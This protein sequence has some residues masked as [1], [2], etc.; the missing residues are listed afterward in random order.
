M[1]P[2]LSCLVLMTRTMFGWNQTHHFSRNISFSSTGAWLEHWRNIGGTLLGCLLVHHWNITRIMVEVSLNIARA[3]QE[4]WRNISRTLLGCLLVHHWNIT[5]ML[6][7]DCLNV[8]RALQEHCR[9]IGGTSR[10]RGITTTDRH[11]PTGEL[12]P[13]PSGRQQTCQPHVKQ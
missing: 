11:P 3:L 7:E 13:Q 4:H 2:K 1:R 6:V 10:E 8:A 9:N 12:H 5:V